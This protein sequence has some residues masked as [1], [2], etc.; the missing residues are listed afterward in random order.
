MKVILTKNENSTLT[1]KISRP[2]IVTINGHPRRC[3]TGKQLRIK[4]ALRQLNGNVQCSNQKFAIY[5]S[6]IRKKGRKCISTVRT[7]YYYL[8]Y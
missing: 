2:N 6:L 5:F 8:R 1:K 7:Y 3:T 4:I